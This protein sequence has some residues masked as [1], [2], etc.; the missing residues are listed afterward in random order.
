MD[1]KSEKSKIEKQI[2]I[3]SRQIQQLQKQA[4]EV[5]NENVKLQ[6]ELR[7]LEILIKDKE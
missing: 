6:G 1:F 3:T 7:L 4:N 2:E 5:A